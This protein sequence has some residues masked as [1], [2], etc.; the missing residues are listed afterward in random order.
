[1]Q[2]DSDWQ[3]EDLHAL[4]DLLGE[5]TASGAPVDLLDRL[6]ALERVKSAAAGAQVRLAATFAD[7]AD[8]EDVPA[9]GRRTPPRA[10]SVGAEV[11]RTTLASQIGRAH[12]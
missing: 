1:M 3:A 10:M 9:P 4:A 2:Q 5:L 12:V 11:A 8:T 6:E 7:A